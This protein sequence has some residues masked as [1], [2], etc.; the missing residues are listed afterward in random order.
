MQ[1]LS[2]FEMIWQLGIIACMIVLILILIGVVLFA[3][4]KPI[5]YLD[6]L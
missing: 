1:P 2:L 4:F 5:G 6:N 3:V